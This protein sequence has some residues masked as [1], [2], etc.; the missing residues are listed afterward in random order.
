MKKWI[1][2]VLIAVLV[3]VV[4]SIVVIVDSLR[5][6]EQPLEE[7]V[8][9]AKKVDGDN[10]KGMAYAYTLEKDENSFTVTYYYAQTRN[11]TIITYYVE[12]GIVTKAYS[13]DHFTTKANARR[14]KSE[15]IDRTIEGNVVKGWMN[16]EGEN[17]S[18]NE[19]YNNLENSLKDYA[20]ELK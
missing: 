1:K 11:K 4:A 7:V 14:Y 15:L 6:I 20:V 8:E 3:I 2:F 10:I 5:V 13:E 9:I 17:K 19:W 16:L 18:G 12:N